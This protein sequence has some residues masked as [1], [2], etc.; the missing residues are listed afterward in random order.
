MWPQGEATG[1]AA[2][3]SQVP[4]VLSQ[5]M[6][7]PGCTGAGWPETFVKDA[8]IAEKWIRLSYI[9]IHFVQDVITGCNHHSYGQGIQ[10]EREEIML[11]FGTVLKREGCF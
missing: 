1:K 6:E 11:L 5:N 4:C 8:G 7:E 3:C 10:D 9:L 2:D